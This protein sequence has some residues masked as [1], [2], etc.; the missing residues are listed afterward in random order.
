MTEN[1]INKTTHFQCT[2]TPS[3]EAMSL[4][5][6]SPDTP[7]EDPLSQPV[8]PQRKYPPLY[9]RRELISI[10]MPSR[11]HETFGL[12]VSNVI[13]DAIR[14]SA[15]TI[16]TSFPFSAKSSSNDGSEPRM[17]TLKPYSL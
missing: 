11:L 6:L 8:K 1:N 15:A 3:T 7:P 14:G 4:T 2:R 9:A 5:C 13:F 10:H 16:M 12:S 17:L